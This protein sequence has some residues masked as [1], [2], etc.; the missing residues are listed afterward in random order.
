MEVS[1][2][3]EILLEDT[4]KIIL[5]MESLELT[6][7]QDLGTEFR[8]SKFEDSN[9]T[10]TCI[11]KDDNISYFY[12]GTDG[13][14]FG[15]ILTLVQELKG[16]NF[17]ESIDYICSIIGIS[18][19]FSYTPK[20]MPFGGYFQG[21]TSYNEVVANEVLNESILKE[22]PFSPSLR[23]FK[24]NIDLSVQKEFN[25]SYDYYTDRIVVPWR[26]E[27]GGLIGLMGRYN[28]STEFIHNNG[29]AKWKPLYGYNFEKSQALFGYYENKD[30]IMKKK[31]VF[32]GESEKFAMQLK[33]MYIEKVDS[34]GEVIKNYFDNGLGLGKH[35]IS[36]HQ[37][38]L[39]NRL[40]V[41]YKILCLDE[42]LEEEVVIKEANKL[43]T[44]GNELVGYIWDSENKYLPK[45]SLCSPS[46]LGVKIF[47]KL[48]EECIKW[49]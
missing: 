30:S 43:K 22:Y 12:N 38:N 16:I 40:N 39:I 4:E 33:S 37:I 25:I 47:S 17:R 35:S 1:T 48:I 7:I 9:P 3:K 23:F 44:N 26:N 46:D 5:V 45:G 15:D 24:D 18:K 49:I 42:G 19:D 32:I 41:K 10:G 6:N 2:L 20:E 14:E 11:K 34:E 31:I 36:T 21:L 27:E 13:S 29:I 28:D 8:A